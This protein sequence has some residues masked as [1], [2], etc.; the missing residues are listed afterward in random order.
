MVLRRTKLNKKGV[1]S[2]ML[3]LE[4]TTELRAD[5]DCGHEGPVRSDFQHGCTALAELSPGK[6]LLTWRLKNYIAIAALQAMDSSQSQP[7][8][9]GLFVTNLN[10]G[11]IP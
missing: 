5:G 1:V 11:R 4:C 2:V 3:G 10:R 8:V 9:L 7:C 6:P